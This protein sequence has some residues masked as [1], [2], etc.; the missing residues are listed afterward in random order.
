MTKKQKWLPGREPKTQEEADRLEAKSLGISVEALHNVRR[1]MDALS[2][3]TF[4]LKQLRKIRLSSKSFPGI[5]KIYIYGD[6][7]KDKHDLDDNTVT[8]VPR[9]EGVIISDYDNKENSIKNYSKAKSLEKAISDNL[10]VSKITGKPYI[11]KLVGSYELRSDK[12]EYGDFN[13][14]F[15][16]FK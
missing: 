10:P 6:R 15:N 9:F 13:M 7:S 1:R 4:L 5:D 16:P 11:I 8:L 12:P 14:S 2:D 3:N